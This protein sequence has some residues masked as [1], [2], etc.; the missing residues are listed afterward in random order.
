MAKFSRYILFINRLK[1]TLKIFGL[2]TWYTKKPFGHR[3]AHN[4]YVLTSCPVKM[5]RFIIGF[6]QFYLYLTLRFSDVNFTIRY[7]LEF[8]AFWLV[9]LSFL[10]VVQLIYIWNP[11]HKTFNCIMEFGSMTGRFFHTP[12][13]WSK[14]FSLYN[15]KYLW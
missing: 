2:K 6:L 14:F 12:S 9:F 13:L 3:V 4:G 5:V 1:L 8:S 10:F 11:V 7:F 15:K